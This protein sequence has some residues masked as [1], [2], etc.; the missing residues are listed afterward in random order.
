MKQ[1]ILSASVLLILSLSVAAEDTIGVSV[2]LTTG[3]A[4]TPTEAVEQTISTVLQAIEGDTRELTQAQINARTQLY[5]ALTNISSA[6][7]SEKEAALKVISPKANTANS[8]ITRRNPVGFNMQAASSRFSLLR[9]STK[10]NLFSPRSRSSRSSRTVFSPYILKASDPN[11]AG[12]LFDNRLSTFFSFNYA[13]SDQSETSVKAGFKGGSTSFSGGVDYR[14]NPNSYTGV[15]FNYM[16]ADVD[17]SSGG[18]LESKAYSMNAYGAYYLD[19]NISFQGRVGFGSMNYDMARDINYTV[20]GATT[21]TIAYSNPDGGYFGFSFGAAFDKSI[22]QYSGG[23]FSN[24]NF[25]R[26]SIDG[27]AETGAG[28]YDLNVDQQSVNS[29]ALN[30]GGQVSAVFSTRWWIVTP[31]FKATYVKEFNDDDEEVKAYFVNDPSKTRMVFDAD[32]QD[33][34]YLKSTLGSSFVLPQGISGFVQLEFTHLIQNYNQTNF[35]L[36]VRKEL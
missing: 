27:F 24:L 11:E 32:T 35:A 6:A 14:L 4:N 25:S 26:A 16:S 8:T 1:K 20:N 22:S 7:P 2:D 33:P 3:S 30:I 10:T 21:N 28:G 17:L 29:L 34:S 31:Y 23:V 13:N 19:E 36:G 5:D 12:G 15:A 9:Q 18:G